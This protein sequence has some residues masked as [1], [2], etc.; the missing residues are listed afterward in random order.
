MIYTALNIHDIY[1]LVH[2]E[3][4]FPLCLGTVWIEIRKMDGDR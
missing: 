3:A 2:E 1:S 4:Q